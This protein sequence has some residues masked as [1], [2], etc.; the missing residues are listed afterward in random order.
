MPNIAKNPILPG[1]YP[2]PS[3]CRVG[4]DY[5][6]TTSTFSYFPGLPIFHSTD[7][8]NWTQI[9]NAI[10]RPSQLDFTDQPSARGLYAPTIRFHNGMFFIICT[11]VGSDGNFIITAKDPA[12]PWSDPIWL[13]DANGIDP[14]LLF[15]GDK[16]W[17]TGTRPMSPA[18]AYDGN[19]EVWVQELDFSHVAEGKVTTV[20]E[21]YAIWSGALKGC[22]WPEGPHLYKIGD[23]YYLLAA[24]GGTSIDHASMI[25]RAKS[26]TEPFVGKP[27]NP[28][29]THRHLGLTA[30]IVNVGHADLFDTPQGE[31]YMVCLASRPYG[32]KDFA[33][34]ERSQVFGRE[35]FLVPVTWEDGWPVAAPGVGLIENQIR[36]NT[37]LEAKTAP[38]EVRH[39]PVIDTFTAETLPPYWL[40]LRNS[41][42]ATPALIQWGKDGLH[43]STRGAALDS[44]ENVSF[45]ARRLMHKN[46]TVSAKVAFT[47]KDEE[48]TAGIVL[49]RE[50]KFQ[51]RYEIAKKNGKR[52]V[53]FV[54]VCADKT[55]CSEAVEIGG[56]ENEPV[57]LAIAADRLCLTFY[58]AQGNVGSFTDA[59]DA[60]KPVALPQT[61]CAILGTEY[62]GGCG[63]TGALTG[64]FATGGKGE[65]ATDA[66]VT[67]FEYKGLED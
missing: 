18:P 59:R 38:Y 58:L 35:T 67:L 2:D 23:W 22:I 57:S 29:L 64:V 52:V 28:I 6:L 33:Q 60:Y 47:P 50:E 44:F 45:V 63:F 54:R 12:G 34:G 7:L 40:T 41:V 61:S 46:W 26:P 10:H 5:Y 53:R 66:H 42:L 24:E 3:I 4:N 21:S 15:D 27:A 37:N 39:Q 11:I 51:I 56:N 25:A 36:V 48:E 31:W 62:T 55:E 43:L 1:F 65:A 49:F 20:G 16:V 9:G 14:S 30:E 17:Y 13:P 32:S 8:V 19:W